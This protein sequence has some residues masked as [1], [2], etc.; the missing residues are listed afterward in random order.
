[1]GVVESIAS[2]GWSVPPVLQARDAPFI[3]GHLQTQEALP[4]RI[5]VKP[6]ALFV[7]AS[8]YGGAIF[9]RVFRGNAARPSG[10]VL[11]K[12]ESGDPTTEGQ[13][14]RRNE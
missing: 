8:L 7:T 13:P 6:V 9:R 10:T 5:I 4:E 12:F 3:R 14:A 11:V 2:P 1:M